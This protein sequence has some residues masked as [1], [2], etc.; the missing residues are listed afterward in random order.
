MEK[1]VLDITDSVRHQKQELTTSDVSNIEGIF[2][3]KLRGLNIDTHSF[4]TKLPLKEDDN[5]F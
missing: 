5:Y 1:S 3:V 4:N 2:V